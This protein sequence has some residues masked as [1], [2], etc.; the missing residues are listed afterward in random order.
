MDE[1]YVMIIQKGN[2]IYDRL[3]SIYDNCSM[4]CFDDKI[5]MYFEEAV[6][7]EHETKSPIYPCKNETRD[8]YAIPVS[9]FHYLHMLDGECKFPFECDLKER[10]EYD[11]V[12]NATTVVP[13]NIKDFIRSY[14]NRLKQ[15]L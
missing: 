13:A 10:I 14:K 9:L 8:Y 12:E 1:F 5:G 11:L 15:A 3:Y 4:F 2:Q 6:K 7:Q